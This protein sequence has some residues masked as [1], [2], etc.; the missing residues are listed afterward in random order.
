MGLELDNTFNTHNDKT[1]GGQT[2]TC[3]ACAHDIMKIIEGV[4][5]IYKKGFQGILE[6]ALLGITVVF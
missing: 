5:G 1:K 3:L 6:E 2:G 4:M